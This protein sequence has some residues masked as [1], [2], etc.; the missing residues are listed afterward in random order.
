MDGSL[1]NTK[2]KKIAAVTIA[3]AALAA[4]FEGEVL[5]PYQDIG[6]VLTVCDG[7]T[8][9]DIQHK[10]YTKEE[11]RHLLQNDMRNAVLSVDRCHPDLPYNVWV[12]MGDLAYNEGAGKVCS[13]IINYYLTRKDYPNA[14]RSMLRFNHVNSK[15]VRGLTRRRQKD[16]EICLTPSSE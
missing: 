8:G 10:R 12:A 15:E 6:G 2:A 16:Y 3:A 9:N 4:P 11:C 5:T 1:L 13:G 14:C 7:H